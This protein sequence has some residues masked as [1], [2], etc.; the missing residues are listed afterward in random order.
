MADPLDRLGRKAPKRDTHYLI[1]GFLELTLIIETEKSGLMGPAFKAR[2]RAL[3]LS[4]LRTLWCNLLGH[5]G[6]DTS[7]ASRGSS[8][9]FE[10]A[11][12]GSLDVTQAGFEEARSLAELTHGRTCFSGQI[13]RRDLRPSCALNP[14]PSLETVGQAPSERSRGRLVVG[15]PVDHLTRHELGEPP[16]LISLSTCPMGASASLP[17]Q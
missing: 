16:A 3:I 10:L 2:N 5:L 4:C 6:E 8:T 15:K 12:G 9:V 14:N 17:S 1:R 7:V 13:V 11:D